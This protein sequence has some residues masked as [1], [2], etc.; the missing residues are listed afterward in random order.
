MG[1][2]PALGLNLGCCHIIHLGSTTCPMPCV[3]RWDKVSK[4]LGNTLGFLAPC[5][6]RSLHLCF[7]LFDN[8]GY[9]MVAHLCLKGRDIMDT[10]TPYTLRSFAVTLD[11]GTPVKGIV[12][13]PFTWETKCNQGLTDRDLLAGETWIVK[14]QA[15][16]RKAGNSTEANKLANEFIQGLRQVRS[17]PVVAKVDSKKL[18]LTKDQILGLAALGIKFEA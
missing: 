8:S 13:R 11:N 2:P 6:A 16:I 12:V 5:L 15:F 3:P 14:C 7:M 10:S 9:G 17:T 18:A 1:G 4:P